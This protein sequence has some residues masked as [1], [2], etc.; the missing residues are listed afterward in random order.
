LITKWHNSTAKKLEKKFT[1]R[2]IKMIYRMCSKDFRAVKGCC[3]KK[4]VLGIKVNFS[5][6]NFLSKKLPI[7]RITDGRLTFVK[8]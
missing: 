6:S 3:F 7:K 4:V 1:V 8:G 5:L 2:E